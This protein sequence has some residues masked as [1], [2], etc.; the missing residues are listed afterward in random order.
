MQ[1]SGPNEP[2]VAMFMR[3]TVRDAHAVTVCR[4]SCERAGADRHPHR[5][6]L[7]CGRDGSAGGRSRVCGATVEYQQHPYYGRH[8][9]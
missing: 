2:Q 8:E 1:T 7:G 6:G 9:R 5:P 4:C 3:R